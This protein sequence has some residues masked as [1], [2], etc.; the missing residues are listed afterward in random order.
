M[1]GAIFCRLVQSRRLQP[2]VLPGAVAELAA[3]HSLPP[4]FTDDA[5]AGSALFARLLAAVVATE[6]P[7]RHPHAGEHYRALQATASQAAEAL[8]IDSSQWSRAGGVLDWLSRHELVAA[9]VAK[10]GRNGGY[11]VEPGP[12]LLELLE[13]GGRRLTRVLDERGERRRGR[14]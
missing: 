12:A 7:A 6:I 8:N 13:P 1:D 10:T 3:G 5:P 14:P 4:P 9:V 11:Y 2:A